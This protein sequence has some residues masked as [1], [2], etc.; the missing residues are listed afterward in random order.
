MG[1]LATA[2]PHNSAENTTWGILA[3]F[4]GSHLKRHIFALVNKAIQV[5]I[6]ILEVHKPGCV[7]IMKTD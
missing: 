2:S 7:S 4:L 6:L 5:L 3:C 1:K